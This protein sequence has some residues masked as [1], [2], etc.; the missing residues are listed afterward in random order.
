M[1]DLEFEDIKYV[2]ELPYRWD[3]L[4]NKVVLISGGT[5]FIGSFLIKVIQ[6]RNKM[7]GSNVKVVSVSRRK[8]QDQEDV[9][10]LR[11]DITNPLIYDGKIDYI[12]HLASNTHPAQYAEDPVGTITTNIIGCD[13]LLKLAV[14]NKA[15]RFLLASSVEIYGQ[16]TES[17]M[18]ESYS[19]YIDCNT[20]RA[21]YNEAKRTC[22]SLCESYKM[23]YGVE[24]V[25]ARLART[26]GPDTKKDTKAM[27]QFM[28]KAV[29][30]EDIILKSMGN[31]RF[32]YIYVAD[33]V[34]GIFKIL[35]E[36]H[37][38]EAYNVSGKDEHMTLRNYAEFIA[39]LAK[40]KFRYQFEDNGA[41]SKATYALMDTKKLESI[42]W[43]P[44]YG[45]CEALE[46]TYN[47]YLTREKSCEKTAFSDIFR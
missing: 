41:V 44:M 36:G 42:G 21:G 6:Y 1:T 26:I 14:E 33:A 2:A 37:V 29:S 20:A 27:A 46:R 40:M 17:L 11:A 13:N 24:C 22:E 3:Q 16:G 47:I 34:S 4:N 28:S 25:I 23:Q 18:D 7:Y 19:G 5:G 30:G 35:L 9:E 12:L 10:Y 32:S 39:G 45:I 8:M 43:A 31:Q 15:E 38:G